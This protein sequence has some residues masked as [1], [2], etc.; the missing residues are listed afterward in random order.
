MLSTHESVQGQ[1][2]KSNWEPTEA[3]LNNSSSIWICFIQNGLGFMKAIREHLLAAN[4]RWEKCSIFNMLCPRTTVVYLW[5][6]SFCIISER[7]HPSGRHS[8][9]S[10]L[11]NRC[12]GWAGKKLLH[13]TSAKSSLKTLSRLATWRPPSHKRLCQTNCHNCCRVLFKLLL[14]VHYT[15]SLKIP[16]QV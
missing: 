7:A 5:D 12:G 15:F 4:Q 1:L 3:L 2:G 13:R 10:Q 9:F 16:L 14:S 6:V 8:A 11:C